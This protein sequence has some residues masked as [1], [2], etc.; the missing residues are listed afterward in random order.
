MDHPHLV[1]EV[2][3]QD[4]D[5]IQDNLTA[6]VEAAREQ[7]MLAGGYGIVVTQH[8][9]DSFTVALSADVP[10]GQTREQRQFRTPRPG[11]HQN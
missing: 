2:T 6:A 8:A 3:G 7:A 10:Y 9:S 11:A 4:P 5:V 1:L